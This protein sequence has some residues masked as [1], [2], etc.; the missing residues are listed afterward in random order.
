[1]LPCGLFS[2]RKS[3]EI[4][5]V[6]FPHDS[7]GEEDVSL[8]KTEPWNNEP[9]FRYRSVP[10]SLYEIIDMYTIISKN[11]KDIIY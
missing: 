5:F 8:L 10:K 7:R 1:M 9:K 6:D 3:N 11:I 2:V 4:C